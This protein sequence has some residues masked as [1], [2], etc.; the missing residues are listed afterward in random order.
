MDTIVKVTTTF[1]FTNNSEMGD[2]S[3]KKGFGQLVHALG[4]QLEESDMEIPM[5]WAQLQLRALMSSDLYEGKGLLGSG[6]QRPN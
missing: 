6:L 5:R 2:V 4:N 1:A 3:V